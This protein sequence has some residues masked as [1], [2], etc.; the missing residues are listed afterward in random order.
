LAEVRYDTETGAY[1]LTG[2]GE[3]TTYNATA[4][5]LVFD[6]LPSE[7]TEAKLQNRTVKLVIY[8]KTY[9][10]TGDTYYIESIELFKKV[11]DSSGGFLTP[12]DLN[13]EGV[14][15][16]NYVFVPKFDAKD[17]SIKEKD[18][19]KT[20]VHADNVDYGE[21]V[22]QYNDGAEKVRTIAAKESNYFNIFQTIAETF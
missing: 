21:F 5:E 9:T 2:D 19:V 4:K 16:N 10:D 20:I 12:T 18:L 22:P 6:C 17:D 8:P 1:A 3:W 7:M 13:T 11:P 14:V 15:E